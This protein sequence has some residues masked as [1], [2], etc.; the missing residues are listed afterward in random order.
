MRQMQGQWRCSQGHHPHVKAYS[1]KMLAIIDK[2]YGDAAA[3]ESTTCATS[4][5]RICVE[6]EANNNGDE[7]EE[8]SDGSSGQCKHSTLKDC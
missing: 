7:L 8:I 4:V 5:N 3:I 6:N 2:N 1:G